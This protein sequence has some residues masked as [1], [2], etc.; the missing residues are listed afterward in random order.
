MKA[1]ADLNVAIRE[2]RVRKEPNY[3]AACFHSQQCVEKYLKSF[4]EENNLSFP[5]THIL[6][7]L[8]NLCQN[9]DPTFALSPV[10]LKTLTDY[11]VRFRYP[12]ESATKG[13]AQEALKYAQIIRLF[14]RQK[15]GFI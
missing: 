12:G 5:K 11:A 4:L 2:T 15:L 9:A 6:T 7:E 13:D 14:I 8:A 1:D 10:M 3:D